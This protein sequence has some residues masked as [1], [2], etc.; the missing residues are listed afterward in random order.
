MGFVGAAFK[1]EEAQVHESDA[2][3]QAWTTQK[4][5]NVLRGKAVIDSGASD[6]VVGASTLQELAEI[7]GDLGFKVKKEFEVD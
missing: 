6:N 1:T 7:I 2:A 5:E 4:A 3:G